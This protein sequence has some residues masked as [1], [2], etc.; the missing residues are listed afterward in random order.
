M[1]VTEEVSGILAG[2][3]SLRDFKVLGLGFLDG[4]RGRSCGL[5]V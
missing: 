2:Y 1:A 4:F 5:T 3:P